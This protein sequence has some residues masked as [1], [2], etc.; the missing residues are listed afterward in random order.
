MESVE[1]ERMVA[2]L[3]VKS[4]LSPGAYQA[5]VALLA[6]VGFGLLTLIVGAAG[7]A[8]IALIGVPVAMWMGGLH[9]YWLLVGAGKLLLLLAIPLWLLIKSTMSA[10]LTRF[11]IPQGIELLSTQAPELFKAL[12]HM[13][14]KMRGPRFHHVLISHEL[15]AA[16][17]QRP[18]FG[19]FG[20]PRNYLIVG[21]PLLESLSP[22]EALA[23]VAHE[24]GHLAGSHS[25]FGA[26][27]YR[28]RLTWTTVYLVSHQWTG[29]VSKAL[30]RL[31]GLYVP[32]FNA[33]SFVLA[34]ANE[35]QADA[36][37]AQLVSAGVM[38]NALIRVEVCGTHFNNFL[39]GTYKTA[40]DGAL[41]PE[42]VFSRWAQMV[43]SVPASDANRWLTRALAL[44]GSV[45][46][47]HPPLRA[48]LLALLGGGA[49][50]L[51]T[52]ALPRIASPS[53]A[54]IWLGDSAQTVRESIQTHWCNRIATPWKR[55]FEEANEQR[56][57][58]DSLR[59]LSNPTEKEHGERLRLQLEY[60]P[61][62][63]LA[64]DLDAFIAAYPTNVL[65]P[66]LMGNWRLIQND[67]NGLEYLDRAMALDAAVTKPV[68]E[69]ALT[70]LSERDDPRTQVYEQRW[71]ERDLWDR[72]AAP[73]L[74]SL[75]E[76]HEL[77][78]P[79]VSEEHMQT[80]RALT[81]ANHA[82]ITRAFLVR[83]KVPADPSFPSYVLALQLDPKRLAIESPHQIVSR[84][85]ET[86]AW[87][88]HMFFVVLDGKYKVL[89]PRIQALPNAEI[90]LQPME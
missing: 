64:D 66:Y 73:Q 24:Y 72:E 45:D 59:A 61:H 84:L 8:I 85:A 14:H 30:R 10:L 75:D 28:L 62:T 36:A 58:L 32:Y 1:F 4:Q 19:L 78:E 12:D 49:D 47:T 5:N 60:A 15:N 21:L 87:P 50:S 88:V 71:T 37:A 44:P 23:V 86:G 80:I 89:L 55:E 31:V 13:R 11:P 90:A 3:Q 16:V 53:A 27:I 52:L 39:Q 68:C 41:P 57:K 22:D 63:L 20:P 38:A 35:Y 7:A 81:Q 77:C 2:R 51:P 6:L 9:A 17:V 46:D 79:D 33:Y 69:R 48:R 18:M 43:H 34:R 76:T 42:D 29:Y 54:Q 25:H 40:K 56:Q 70:Y 65:G 67:D 82:G 26:F 74:A 83:R